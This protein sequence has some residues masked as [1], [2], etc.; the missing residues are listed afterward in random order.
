MDI[1][2][3]GYFVAVAETGSFT[4]AAARVHISQSGVSAQIRALEHELGQALFDRSGKSVTLTGAG[5]A[6]LPH[7]RAAITA[8]S[9]V[10]QAVD[11]LTGLV[12]GQVSV[13]MVT[14]CSIPSLFDQLADFHRRHPG[15]D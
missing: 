12:H 5:A 10:N 11:E 14:A 1:R 15:I 9:G 3:L 6:V 7:A 8:V 2:Q 13:G 4:Q